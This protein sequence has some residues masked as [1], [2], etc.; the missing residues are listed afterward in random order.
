MVSKIGFFVSSAINSLYIPEFIVS[1]SA[2]QVWLQS[3]WYQNSSS[4]K[5]LKDIQSWS[6]LCS[7]LLIWKSTTLSSHKT[8]KSVFNHNIYIYKSR[9]RML[10]LSD[11][12]LILLS[13]IFLF[14]C[15]P[16]F[17]FC[18]LFQQQISGLWNF[19]SKKYNSSCPHSMNR[20]PGIAFMQI[21]DDLSY[22]IHNAF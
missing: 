15:I 3:W 6:R 22:V 8:L 18:L 7:S 16:V 20:A 19:P 9:A 12:F 4:N 2:F 14:W 17:F 5:Q 1:H 11:R 10:L 21:I 13:F